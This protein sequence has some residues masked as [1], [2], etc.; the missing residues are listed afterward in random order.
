MFIRTAICAAALL[1]CTPQAAFAADATPDK[2]LSKRALDDLSFR[3]H[4]TVAPY[5]PAEAPGGVVLVV[6]DGQTVL[7]RA[8]GMADTIKGVKM[9]PEMAMRI[10]S[11]TKQFT[12]TGI[13]L[14]ADEGKLSVDDEITR[15]LPDY[16]R[17]ARRSPSNT[18]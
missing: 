7:R 8:Y 16:R 9:A 14:L 15:Y 4:A 10:G 6:K 18:C 17:R 13:L 12:A 5:F 2:P 11:M 3:L 1:L